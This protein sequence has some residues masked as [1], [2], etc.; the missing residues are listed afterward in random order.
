MMLLSTVFIAFGIFL[1]MPPNIMPLAGEGAMK[2]VSDVSGIAFSKIKTGFDI[3]MVTVSLIACLFF[4][5]NLGSVGAGTV[6]AA[7]LVGTI[8]GMITNWFG[9]R[10]DTWL[11]AI[12]H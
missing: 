6:I 9:E 2:A 4:I 12:R 7:I 11:G 3:S 10:R 5:R 1:Y 8:L